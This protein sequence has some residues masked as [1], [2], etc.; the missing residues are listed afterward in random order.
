LKLLADL[1]REFDLTLVFVSHDLAVVRQVSDRVA[2]MRD[3]R[4]VEL[5]DT[6]TVFG[7][8][9]HRYT[10]NLLA[11]VPTLTPDTAGTP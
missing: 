4:I 2:V 8:P 10:R 9:E 1:Q 5:A 7:Q 6:D 3:G 11:A